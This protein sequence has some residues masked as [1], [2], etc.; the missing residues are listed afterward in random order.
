MIYSQSKS[1]IAYEIIRDKI[2]SLELAPGT[3]IDE[4]GLRESLG[5]GRT[6]I[7]EALQ[8]L[9]LEKLVTIIPRR[10]MFVTE[11]GLS[12]LQRLSEMRLPLEV[13]AADLAIQRGNE[14]HWREMESIL[15]QFPESRSISNLDWIRID[16]KCHHIIYAA[17]DNKFLIDSLTTLYTLAL[18]LWFY[19]LN[20]MTNVDQA[21]AE[22][23]AILDALRLGDRELVRQLVEQ[24]ITHFQDNIRRVMLNE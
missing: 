13:M 4:A 8:R 3:V 11:I 7:R 17:S 16:E 15:N 2:V 6:P 23:R 9:S 14:S 24:H 5:L 21:V 10:G 19:A 18:R 20:E 12:D 22:H 1:Q